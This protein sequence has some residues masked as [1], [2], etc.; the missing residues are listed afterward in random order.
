MTTL[1]DTS[2]RAFLTALAASGAAA[3][4][5]AAPGTVRAAAPDGV[6]DPGTPAT[7]SAA[8]RT[9]AFPTPTSGTSY[10]FVLGGEFQPTSDPTVPFS[11]GFGQVQ[12][13]AGG[14]IFFYALNEL[15]TGARITEVMFSVQKTA[16]SSPDNSTLFI[17]RMTSGTAIALLNSQNTVALAPQPTEQFVSLVVD[18]VSPLWVLDNQFDASHWLVVTLG[19]SARV[20]S[21]RIGYVPGPTTPLAFVPIA[22]KRAYDS[23][24]VAPLGPLPNNTNRVISVADSYVPGTG[25]LE[26]TNIIPPTAR[27]I[28]YNLTVANTLGSGFLSVNPGDAVAPGGS[29]INWFGPGQLL[30]NGLNVNLNANRQ[31]NVFAGGGGTADFIIDVM[32]YYV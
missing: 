29:S 32:G 31:V 11:K 25:T 28:A 15:P 9:E 21:V 7:P 22:P 16:V 3:A 13:T 1:N 8:P 24:F 26:Q 20:N 14:L 4:V 6:G 19:T 30:A 12:T 5:V 18:P 27:A 10:K 23:R 2:R 17:Y